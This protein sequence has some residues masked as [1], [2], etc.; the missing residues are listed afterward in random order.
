MTIKREKF[1]K[2]NVTILNNTTVTRGKSFFLVTLQLTFYSCV[3]PDEIICGNQTSVP[4]YSTTLSPDILRGP[5][6]EK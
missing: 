3:I 5:T 4:K 1:G 2:Q 6:E